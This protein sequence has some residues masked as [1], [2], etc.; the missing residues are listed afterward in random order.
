MLTN[1]PTDLFG[2]IST[3]LDSNAYHA[4]ATTNKDM[5]KLTKEHCKLQVLNVSNIHPMLANFGIHEFRSVNVLEISYLFLLSLLLPLMAF[6]QYSHQSLPQVHHLIF[7]CS[8]NKSVYL[9]DGKTDDKILI[10]FFL[11]FV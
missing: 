2:K 11:L 9:R 7:V 10:L 4:L 6:K 5:N 8:K 1:L 3:Y